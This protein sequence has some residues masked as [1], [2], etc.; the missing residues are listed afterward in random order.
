MVRLYC[1]EYPETRLVSTHAK[2]VFNMAHLLIIRAFIRID[3]T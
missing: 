2:A 3:L 1:G